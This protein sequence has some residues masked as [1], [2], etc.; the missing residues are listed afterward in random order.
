MTD[1]I[2]GF[3]SWNNL[4][5]NH[6][7]YHTTVNWTQSVQPILSS[8]NKVANGIC[9]KR[10]RA[11]YNSDKVNGMWCTLNKPTYYLWKNDFSSQ[12]EYETAK[13]LYKNLGFRVVTYLDGRSN[14]NIHNGLKALIKNHSVHKS[15]ESCQM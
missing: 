2:I 5:R 10:I 6:I 15:Y 14:K 8:F 11:S 12:E 4:C 7:S 13:E 9:N 3:L 1:D